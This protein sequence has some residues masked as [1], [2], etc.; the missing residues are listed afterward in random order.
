MVID[1]SVTSEQ[2]TLCGSNFDPFREVVSISEVKN[3]LKYLQTSVFVERS[4]L[5]QRVPYQ[6]FH[7]RLIAALFNLLFLAM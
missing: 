4:S 5:S 2:G 6:R 7:C 3:T 1:Y